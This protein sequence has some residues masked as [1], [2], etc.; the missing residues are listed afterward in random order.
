MKT[1]EPE[2]SKKNHIK[3]EEQKKNKVQNLSL[4]DDGQ[5]RLNETSNF[6]VP[7]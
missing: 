2:P 6:K 1:L 4:M 3:K 5:G 7:I